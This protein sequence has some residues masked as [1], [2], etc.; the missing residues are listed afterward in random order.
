[1]HPS[2]FRIGFGIIGLLVA[3][4]CQS[5]ASRNESAPARVVTAYV[6]ADRPFSEPILR[7]YERRSGVRVNVVYDTEETKST[8]LANRLLAERPRPQADV[9]WSIEP[10]RTLV[11]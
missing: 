6:S 5:P 2:P 1:M 11:L 10:V 4:G 7:D 9:F 8:G 3:V